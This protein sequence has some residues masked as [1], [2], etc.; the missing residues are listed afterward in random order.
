MATI[1]A[2]RAIR[3]VKELAEKVAALPYD[4]MSREEAKKMIEGN[5]F[6]FLRV[7]RAEIELDD[8]IPFDNSLVYEKA[9]ENLK[10]FI[11]KGILVQ[12]PKEYL[13]LY[14][15]EFEG[16]SQA[17]LVA[18]LSVDEYMEG[19]IKRHEHTRQD[20]EQDRTKHILKCNANTGP[21]LMFYREQS[22]IQETIDEWMQNKAPLNN[23]VSEDGIA[24]RIWVIDNPDTI[25]RL[26]ELYR[27][28]KSLYI[29]DGHHRCAAAAGACL[30]KRKNGYKG[31]EEFNFFLGV[32]FPHS[33]L[34]ILDYNRVVSDL[35]DMTQEEFIKAI[36]SSNRGTGTVF[37]VCPVEQAKAYRPQQKHN[38]GMFTGNKWYR[39]KA[40][41]GS[42]DSNDPVESLDVSI[43]QKNLLEPVL[44]IKDLRTDERIEFVGGI[45]GL[46]ELEKRVALGAAAAFSLY[47]TSIQELMEVADAGRVMPPKSTWFE[48]K[49]RS[50]LFIHDLG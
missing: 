20:K 19:I 44:G 24:H 12:D 47:P 3:P 46:E 17:G 15:L 27:G 45:R 8:T 9:S 37:E 29:A 36:P 23:F 4:V 7:D 28:V 18:C 1:K 38:M 43:L 25:K 2:F 42:W 26:A 40:I 34:R 14:R 39:L 6:S 16:K 5:E 41:P 33:Q 11:R 13:Y 48:P 32:I 31:N 10:E 21:I 30:E 35:N 22:E 50:G 49:L